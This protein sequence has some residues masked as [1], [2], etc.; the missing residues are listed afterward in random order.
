MDVTIYDYLWLCDLQMTTLSLTWHFH[1]Y[2]KPMKDWR[3]WNGI[4]HSDINICPNSSGLWFIFILLWLWLFLADDLS[5]WRKMLFVGSMVFCK[6][7]V[8]IKDKQTS[9]CLELYFCSCMFFLLAPVVQAD[10]FSFSPLFIP[11]GVDLKYCS[12]LI[13]GI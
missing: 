5:S 11:Y 1:G 9:C 10:V 12:P 6:E 2:L 8:L 3:I 7:T 4:G 13:W